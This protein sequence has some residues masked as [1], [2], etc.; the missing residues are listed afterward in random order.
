VI[1]DETW[2]DDPL[3]FGRVAAGRAFRVLPAVQ[4][5]ARRGLEQLGKKR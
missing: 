4:V 5:R 2:Q 1:L 3:A